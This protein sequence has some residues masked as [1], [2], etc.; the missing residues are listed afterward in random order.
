MSN[1]IVTTTRKADNENF[2]QSIAQ[3]LGGQ[4]VRREAFSLDAL[5]KIHG[6]E[7]ILLVKKNSLSIVKFGVL[8]L[9]RRHD[10]F[11]RDDNAQSGQ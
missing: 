5:K 8:F 2:A 11:Y 3:K 7:N 4:F 10:K 1:F 9:W 6:A